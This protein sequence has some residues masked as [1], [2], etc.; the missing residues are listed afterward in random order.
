MIK[1]L[2]HFLHDF[3]DQKHQW[4]I[5]LFENWKTIVGKFEDKVTIIR[6]ENNLLVLGVCHPAWA[7]ELF[8]LS[9]MF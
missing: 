9:D 4:K 7:Q 5:K 1:P 2:A 6:I 3:V 8:M